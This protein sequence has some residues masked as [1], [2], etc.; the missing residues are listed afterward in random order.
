MFGT[1]QVKQLFVILARKAVLPVK[2]EPFGKTT[3]PN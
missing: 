3:S 1:A 2:L